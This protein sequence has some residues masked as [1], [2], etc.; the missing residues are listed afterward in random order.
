MGRRPL[1]L[2][3][4]LL[5][6]WLVV[7][8]L[9]MVA[10]ES[11]R[12]PAGWTTS[13]IAEFARTPEEWQALW[14]SLWI[15]VLSVVSAG[16][17]GVPLAFVFERLDFP[18][19]RT[20]GA[21]VALPVVL[22]PLVGVMAFLFL[23]GESGFL[24]RLVRGGLGMTDAPW[25]LA[26]APAILLVHAYSMYVYYYLFTRAGL[27]KV[28]GSMIEAAQSLGATRWETLRRVTLPLLRPHIIAAALLT[29]MTS[30]GSFSAPY[31]FGG[32]FRVMTT[33]IVFTKV[34]GNDAL[35]MV[36][37]VALALVAIA[38]LTAFRRTASERSVAVVGKG[39][40]PA[41]KLEQPVTRWLAAALGW[42]VATVVLLPHATLILISFVPMR[43][44]TT[45]ILPPVYTLANYGA[46]I[47]EPERLRP[48]INSLWMAVVATVAA[49]AL[50]LWAGRAI[51]R[52]RVRLAGVID[53][54]TNVPWAVPGTVLAIALA[55][56]FSVYA[57]WAGRWVLV[58]T[59][60]ILPLAYFVRNIPLTAGPVVAGFRQLDPGLDEAAASLGAGRWATTRRVTIPLLRPALVACGALAFATAVGDFVTS[61]VLYTFETRAISNEIMSALRQNDIG[62]A[63]AFGVVL[64][65]VSAGAM[66]VGTSR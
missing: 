44:W 22:P 35:A 40:P 10:V 12:G 64:M 5:L 50:A 42:T 20:L 48:L 6:L 30:L 28:D 52:R 21:L 7:Y 46:L 1:G 49:L 16:A 39:A 27:A 41:R 34:N 26:G 38:G 55:T 62:I 63:A 56:T 66:A 36:E 65:L 57:P 8:P 58:G 61:V 29:F 33:Q 53:I 32:G 45:Q 19:R 37:T 31:L 18:G 59:F 60:A 11:V 43:T 3:L 15:S 9:V 14:G 2:L 51:V 23:Y 25:R 4:T 24:S 54:L 47:R 13:H 17:I